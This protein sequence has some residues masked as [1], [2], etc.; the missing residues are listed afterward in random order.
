MPK[1][2]VVWVID[3]ETDTPEQAAVVALTVQ[4]EKGSTALYFDVVD[5]ATNEHTVVDLSGAA[6]SG[7]T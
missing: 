3:C 5:L 6:P 1:Y 2:R 4:K 7:T